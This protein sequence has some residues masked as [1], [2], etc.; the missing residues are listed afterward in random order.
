MVK[1]K[2]HLGQHFLEDENIAKNI[3]ELLNTKDNLVLEIG[4]GTGVLTKYLIEKNSTQFSVC[5][6]DTESVTYL[7]KHYPNLNIISKDILKLNLKEEFNNQ[8]ITFIGNYPYNISSQILFKALENKDQVTE[9]IGMFQKEVCLRIASKPGNKTYGILS[10]L[11][12]SFYDISYEF[13]VPPNVFNPPPKVQ[14]G[15]ISMKINP[16]KSPNCDFKLFK[17]IV[18]LTFGQR[19]KKIRNTLKS[20]LPNTAIEEIDALP[21]SAS[22]PEQLSPTD[23]HTLTNLVQGL[24]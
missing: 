14:S 2:K 18:K 1:P 23:F 15:V 10:V 19:R 4:P 3:V 5:E 12:Q 9:L 16:E 22:R 11:L 7:K 6:I 8:K 21:F 20:I 13:T 24:I 17:R